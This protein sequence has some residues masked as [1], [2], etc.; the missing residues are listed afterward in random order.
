MVLIFILVI[1]DLRLIQTPGVLQYSMLVLR[2]FFLRKC[3]S[4]LM[5]TKR[6]FISM[7][8]IWPGGRHSHW[9]IGY[10]FSFNELWI[11][12]SKSEPYLRRHY[13]Y[14]VYFWYLFNEL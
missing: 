5:G 8:S 9:V 7:I 10:F 4:A 11:S 3:F 2:N 13:W 12:Y 6:N 1:H 14:N